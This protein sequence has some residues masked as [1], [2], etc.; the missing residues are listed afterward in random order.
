MTVDR[1]NGLLNVTLTLNAAPTRANATACGRAASTGGIWGAEFWAPSSTLGGA[2]QSNTFYIAYR[3]DANA[4]GVE[5]GVVDNANVTVTSLEFRKIVNGTLGGTCLPTGGPPATGTC[6]I[7][8]TVPS[9]AL[10]IPS[11]GALNNTTGLSLY[12]FGIDERVP[13]TRVI[14]GNTEQADATAALYVSGTGQQ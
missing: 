4:T 1:T 2:D 5:G 14:L 8:M 10:G 3:E 9:A 13:A 11:G 7:S 12:S 6:T